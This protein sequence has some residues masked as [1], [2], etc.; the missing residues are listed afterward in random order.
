[1][2]VFSAIGIQIGGCLTGVV[3]QNDGFTSVVISAAFVLAG[4]IYSGMSI[5]L[6]RKA[7]VFIGLG[8]MIIGNLIS[9]MQDLFWMIGALSYI[10]FYVGGLIS[11]IS[12]ISMLVEVCDN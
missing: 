8:V 6:G 10:M 2:C 12:V 3:I 7:A 1:M 9:L 5:F 4:V 11:G